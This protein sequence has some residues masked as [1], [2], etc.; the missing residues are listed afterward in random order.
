VVTSVFAFY[1]GIP[2][3]DQDQF[4]KPNMTN[5]VA[6]YLNTDYTSGANRAKIQKVFEKYYYR[7]EQQASS[8]PVFWFTR[9][10]DVCLA[11]W[12]RALVDAMPQLAKLLFGL[13][14]PDN[15]TMLSKQY[16]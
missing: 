10:T 11:F 7:D 4:Q 12:I 1:Q 14:W 13:K 9:E 5:F 15:R 8:N 2:K 3:D 16:T 6:T